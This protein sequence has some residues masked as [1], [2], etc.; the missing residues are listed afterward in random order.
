MVKLG[1][2]IQGNAIIGKEEALAFG[3]AWALR[4]PGEPSV[5]IAEVIAN[6]GTGRTS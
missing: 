4:K 1:C 6:A 2:R 3:K 5:N